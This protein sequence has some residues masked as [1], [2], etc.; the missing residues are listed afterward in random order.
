MIDPKQPTIQ[1]GM[2]R[3]TK[4]GNLYEVTGIALQT[5]TNEFLVLYRALVPDPH[6][7]YHYELFARPYNMF[8][9]HVEIDRVI[10]PRFEYI[11]DKN[12]NLRVKI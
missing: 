4:T 12:D 1:T 5:E 7:T 10:V 11:G 8:I 9:E 3:H 6:K 2:Y